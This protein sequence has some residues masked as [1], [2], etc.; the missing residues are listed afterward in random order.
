MAHLEALLQPDSWTHLTLAAV[1]WHQIQ[2]CGH[3][4]DYPDLWLYPQKLVQAT[5]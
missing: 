5:K 1:L 4:Q 2:N 3:Q